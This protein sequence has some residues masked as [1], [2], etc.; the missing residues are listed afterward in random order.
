MPNKDTTYKVQGS[1]K[2]KQV[3]NIALI[4]AAVVLAT[5]IT[6]GLVTMEQIEEFIQLSVY[7]VGSLGAISGLV[8]AALARGNVDPPKED[9]QP[10]LPSPDEMGG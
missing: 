6:I 2:R 3:Y 10:P 8:S 1:T 9:V 5:L 7:L 4:V